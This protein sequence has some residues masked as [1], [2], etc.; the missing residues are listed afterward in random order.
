[1]NQQE[2]QHSMDTGTV[3]ERYRNSVPK[4]YQQYVPFE[5]Q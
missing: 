2:M 1:M 5:K 4:E 3:P